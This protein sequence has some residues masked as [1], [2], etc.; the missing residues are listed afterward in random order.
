MTKDP[1]IG[2]VLKDA[3]MHV[4]VILLPIII[5]IFVIAYIGNKLADRADKKEKEKLMKETKEGY[6]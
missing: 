2:K 5:L 4:F 3:G 1:D 6:L